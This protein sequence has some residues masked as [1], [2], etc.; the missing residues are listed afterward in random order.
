MRDVDRMRYWASWTQPTL[1]LYG[2]H[3][4]LGVPEHGFELA[5]VLPDSEL[6]WLYPEGHFL[7]REQPRQVSERILDWAHRLEG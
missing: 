7:T 4:R 5:R 1:L 2:T 6:H 3:D